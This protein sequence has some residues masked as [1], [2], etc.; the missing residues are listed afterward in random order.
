MDDNQLSKV[1]HLE[2]EKRKTTFILVE[3]SVC[4][5]FLVSHVFCGV[6]GRR[7]YVYTHDDARTVPQPR[8]SCVLCGLLD[9]SY[10]LL[11]REVAVW[12]K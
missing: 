1:T 12:R 9:K 6:C 7:I 3:D 5:S 4:V 8:R 11:R 2:E 10:W